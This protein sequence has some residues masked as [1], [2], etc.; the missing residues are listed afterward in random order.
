MVLGVEGVNRLENE[1]VGV[2]GG[3]MINK[4]HLTAH[5]QTAPLPLPV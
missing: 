3:E 1:G 4:D 5:T 2:G